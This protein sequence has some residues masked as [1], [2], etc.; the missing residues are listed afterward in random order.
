LYSG[1][2]AELGAAEVGC[3]TLA[4]ELGLR[5]QFQET[6][7]PGPGGFLS[8]SLR[9]TGLDHPGIVESI[10]HVLATRDVNVKS[11][12]TH[13]SHAPLTGTPMFVLDAVLQVPAKSPLATLRRELADVC[14]RENLD[15]SLEPRV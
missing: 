11:L 3:E 12:D 4:R 7:P 2:A 6:R 8:Y 5:F 1:T 15:W 9:V 13:L 14:E 10:T